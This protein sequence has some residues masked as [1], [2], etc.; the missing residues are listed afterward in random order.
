MTDPRPKKTIRSSIR[1]FGK[2]RSGVSAIEFVL[3]FPILVALLAGTVDFGQALMVSRKMNQIVS[4]LGDMIAQKSAWTTSEAN[5]I[6][7]GT[8][9]IIL[10]FSTTNL[11]I[12]LAVVDVASDLSTKV[13]W[14][15]A[16]QDTKPAANSASPVTVPSTIAQSGVQLVTVVASYDLTTPFST[17]LQPVTGV[18]T[19]HYSKTYIMRPRVKD[20]ITL[21]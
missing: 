20:T 7:T 5:A 17:L 11:K 14:G 16:Y 9:T 21:D 13:N 2:D 4:T 19:Y 12:K 18:S 3:I 6:I 8:T 1:R 10:P 15:L